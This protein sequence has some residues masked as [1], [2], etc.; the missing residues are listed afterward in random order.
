V[1][2]L[3]RSQQ[4]QDKNQEHEQGHESES[5]EPK[6]RKY[7]LIA[8]I[9]DHRDLKF[10][11]VKKDLL[12]KLSSVPT[13]TSLKSKMPTEIYDQGQL[14][15]C[16]ANALAYNYRFLVSSDPARLFIYWCE[17]KREGTVQSDSGATLR[18]GMKVL[19]QRGV[20]E[21]SLDPYNVDTFKKRPSSEA[22]KEAT[23]H[24]ITKYLRVDVTVDAIKEVLNTGFPV[25]IGFSVPQSFE[26]EQMA[27]DGFLLVPGPKEPI[28]GGHAVCICG[29]DDNLTHNGQTGYFQVINSWGPNWGLGGYFWFPYAMMKPSFVSDCWTIESAT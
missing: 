29:Y 4:K 20:C 5:E 2:S 14:G 6:Q 7:G 23:S 13:S 19:H 27:T 28:I 25:D 21:E 22:F 17:R 18:D 16:T 8:D 12:D 11:I 3:F 24:K 15:S 1:P 26:S 9:P 10:K